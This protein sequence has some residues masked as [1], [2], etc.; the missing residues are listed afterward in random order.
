MLS[1]L[2]SK[3]QGQVTEDRFTYSAVIVDND[4]NQSAKEVVNDWRHK[5]VIPIDYYCEPEQNISLAR[6]KAVENVK[7][8]IIAFID[9]DEFPVKTWLLNLYKTL[10]HYNADGTLGPV[11]PHYP[12]NT[13]IWLIKSKLCERHEH[14]TGTKLHW[15]QT[16]TGN[17]LL[18]KKLFNDKQY[19]FDPV[20]GR[21]GGEDTM[22]FKKHHEN[23]KVFIWC[24]EASV[25]ETVPPERWSKDFHISKNLRI[26][27][28]VGEALRKKENEFQSYSKPKLLLQQIYLLTKSTVWIISMTLCLPFSILFG[29]HYYMR[30]RTKLS[31]NFGLISGFWGCVAIR[32]RD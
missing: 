30:C 13:P 21:T 28:G 18:N 11:K 15:G 8:D 23:G 20:Y 14:K 19:W 4:L 6:N 1:N 26:G 22:F 2:L 32:Y 5:S 3:L 7:G 17:T 27:C 9:D 10:L 29:Q 12:E 16:R 24:N 31:Y 25:Y